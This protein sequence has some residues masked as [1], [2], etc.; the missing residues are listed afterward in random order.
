MLDNCTH[1][2][3]ILNAC[4]WHWTGEVLYLD[5]TVVLTYIVLAS[6]PI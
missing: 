5:S 1:I 2:G 3:A 6:F 4:W